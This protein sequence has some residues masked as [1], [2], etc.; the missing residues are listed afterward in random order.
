MSS[1]GREGSGVDH[2]R[3]KYVFGLAPRIK[4]HVAYLGEEQTVVYPT[5]HA[6]VVLD[7]LTEQQRFITCSREK[8]GISAFCVHAESSVVAVVESAPVPS[9]CVYSAGNPVEKIVNMAVTGIA[10]TRGICMQ[11]S[12]D[13]QYLLVLTGKPDWVLSCWD[14]RNQ[15]LLAKVSVSS[16][17]SVFECSFCPVDATKIC[18]L[19][20][21]LL[22]FY[23]LED[24]TFKEFD[25]IG[26]CGDPSKYTCHSWLLDKTDH[27]L[28]GTRDGQ[29]LLFGKGF[30]QGVLQASPRKNLHIRCII[31][32][33]KGFVV[34]ADGSQIFTYSQS[35]VD[36]DY[37]LEKH[38]E[39]EPEKAH[40]VLGLAVNGS[41]THVA[42]V[43]ANH[44]LFQA[45]LTDADALRGGAST[46]KPLS[47]RFHGPGITGDAAITGLD[48][49]I[50]RSFVV[51]CGRDCSVRVWDYVH[52]TLQMVKYF[53]EEAL[54]VAL[55]PSGYHVLV[56][57][58]DKLR[59]MNVLNDTLTLYK[60]FQIKNCRECQFSD[61][62]QYFAAVHN[63]TIMVYETFTSKLVATL[64][65]HN[66]KVQSLFWADNDT[67][68]L[69]AGLGG[70]VYQWD[71]KNLKREVEFVNKG[72]KFTS[73]VCDSECKT[74]IA[75]GSDR[76]LKLLDF[77]DLKECSDFELDRLFSQVRVAWSKSPVLFAATGEHDKLG[78]VRAFNLPL[79]ATPEVDS[80]EY[81]PVAGTGI[82]R[83]AITHAHD[84]LFVASQ[85]GTLTVLQILV[86]GSEVE[87]AKADIGI[88]FSDHV[89]VTR[90]EIE[91]KTSA[92]AELQASV[93]D[94]ERQNEYQL[95]L[96][97]MNHLEKMKDVSEQY[98][99]KINKARE[100][101]EAL[102]LSK[103]G[104]ENSNSGI[105]G[106][107]NHSQQHELQ[108]LEAEYQ[109][110]IMSE[111]ERYQELKHE[112]TNLKQIFEDKQA[113]LLQEHSNHVE[114]LRREFQASLDHARSQRA[115]ED[116]KKVHEA[117][118]SDEW[119]RQL[120]EDIDSEI[121]EMTREY[122]KKLEAEREATLRFKGENGIMKKR[123]TA[124]VKDIEDQKEEIKA[125]LEKEKKLFA[126]I[127]EQ[128]ERIRAKKRVTRDKDETI[129]L[130]EK[131][132]YELKKKNQELEKF[133]FVLDYRIKELKKQIEPREREITEM[134][135]N[136]KT[137][138][139]E[140]EKYHSSN[141]RLD[142]TIGDL[143]QELDDCQSKITRNS[144]V[145]AQSRQTIKSFQTRLHR[146]I[147]HVQ[148]PAKLDA[149]VID[150]RNR[151]VKE[152]VEVKE[153]D[154]AVV[155]EFE[156]QRQYLQSTVSV[157]KAK[158]QALSDFNARQNQKLMHENMELIADIKDLRQAIKNIR[159]APLLPQG[160][161][162]NAGS[163]RTFFVPEC[164]T[165]QKKECAAL[166]CLLT[167]IC[168]CFIS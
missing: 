160:Q 130:K 141:A 45:K 27:L 18:V 74:V 5:G 58:G 28:V 159:L 125:M 75:V 51:T 70:A 162:A 15:Q 150:L 104:M 97:E 88:P 123:F 137:I 142:A 166:P 99:Q 156:R 133:K 128:G 83:M 22:K 136:I 109:Q 155:A 87:L 10:G 54:S 11:F 59:L 34:G 129:A 167:G 44:Q 103:T 77:P 96:K 118:V 33:T 134:K 151:F 16:G 120:A 131:E 146:T 140:L 24:N 93:Q 41:E 115:E 23:R 149:A 138:D 57:F 90:A 108:K 80:Q 112:V 126:H 50:R 164:L 66:G 76:K 152:D 35:D 101:F 7:H 113:Q 67:R 53:P 14:W 100:E 157:L 148:D 60:E 42:C 78:S 37:S 116:A 154:T 61:G 165:N 32:H 73:A 106:K 62:G 63:S 117:K 94:L 40:A 114:S 168:S 72:N 139:A 31:P 25:V 52:G 68:L 132:I 85:D 89:L 71:I 69:S 48:T 46:F 143:R 30:A 122:E 20:K 153:A 9:I 17:S 64:R 127:T 135:D 6:V 3:T 2:L 19:G 43:L 39:V 21:N 36:E 119:T 55:H 91:E 105:L 82:T 38:F 81:Y 49:C 144:T 8:T 107:I 26:D 79:V 65:G 29:L 47:H 121:A 92:I 102:R 158:S 161:A 13:G 98:Q 111:V 124:L 95:K 56:G 86:S 145:L 1:R 12:T 163:V 147:Q 110:M 4:G 84:H